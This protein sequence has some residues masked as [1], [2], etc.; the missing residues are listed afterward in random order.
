[1]KM[2]SY[3][4]AIYVTAGVCLCKFYSF[5][6]FIFPS[7]ISVIWN[8]VSELNLISK[9]DVN[10]LFLHPRFRLIAVCG[11]TDYSNCTS[12]EGFGTRDYKHGTLTKTIGVLSNQISKVQH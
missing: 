9:K 8:L 1:M 10:N 2:P 11:T 12:E 3:T 6:L 4:L 7:C 5:I